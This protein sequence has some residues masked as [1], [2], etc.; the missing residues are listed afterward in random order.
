M[1]FNKIILLAGSGIFVIIVVV[2]TI[3]FYWSKSFAAMDLNSR[4]YH[5]SEMKRDWLGCWLGGKNR[6]G[7]HFKATDGHSGKICIGGSWP[8]VIT[9]DK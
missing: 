4:G 2:L 6:T 8:S 3:Q 5:I 7:W 9:W 1:K